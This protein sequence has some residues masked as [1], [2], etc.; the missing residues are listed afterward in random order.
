MAPPQAWSSE[1]MEC[2]TGVEAEGDQGDPFAVV[3][4]SLH[5][6]VK[7][8]LLLQPLSEVGPVVRSNWRL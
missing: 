2:R 6:I 1:V 8:E 3:E 7:G 5:R 4:V